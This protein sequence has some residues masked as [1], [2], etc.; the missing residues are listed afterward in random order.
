MCCLKVYKLQCSCV[1]C[2]L[3][4][5]AFCTASLE[6]Q[7]EAKLASM[8][9]TG[10]GNHQ[11]SGSDAAVN[12]GVLDDHSRLPFDSQAPPRRLKASSRTSAPAHLNS[13]PGQLG[14]SQP[15][16]LWSEKDAVLERRTPSPDPS[17]IAL[18]PL[19]GGNWASMVNTPL[20]PLFAGKNGEEP[21][22]TMDPGLRSPGLDHGLRSPSHVNWSRPASDDNFVLDDV[23]KFRRSARINSGA[24]NRNLASPS[25]GPSLGSSPALGP[26]RTA[27]NGSLNSPGLQQ[28]AMTAQQN[29]RNGLNSPSLAQEQQDQ[30]GS[31]I[32]I[33]GQNRGHNVGHGLSQGHIS[34]LNSASS[35]NAQLANL[36]ALQQQLFQQQQ[37][38]NNF[39]AAGLNLS[40]AAT[41]LGFQQSPGQRGQASFGLGNLGGLGVGLNGA[42][43]GPVRECSRR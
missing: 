43:L 2:S 28:A 3:H 18:S 13:G 41:Q 19:V 23:R 4:V 15:S 36:F 6:S 38:L 14:S 20:V 21:G 35:A 39:A 24:V 7:L 40:P 17:A 34:G 29:W 10:S 31:Q 11:S 9:L 27:P 25:L 30:F 8:K 1:E 16:S 32:G 37:Q 22:S 26:S 42:G 12:A 33:G 5:L